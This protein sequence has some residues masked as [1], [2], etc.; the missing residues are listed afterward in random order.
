MTVD[1]PDG[2]A[3]RTSTPHAYPLGSEGR[4]ADRAGA[5]VWLGIALLALA[6]LVVRWPWLGGDVTFPW[7]AKAH[8]QPQIQFLAQSLRDGQSPFWAPYVFTGHPQIADPQSAMVT[9]YLL[10]AR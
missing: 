6:T 9:P 4:F 5:Q 10:L 3:A 1:T 2:N 8:V 7:D